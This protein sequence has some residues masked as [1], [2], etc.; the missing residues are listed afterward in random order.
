MGL[1][2]AA[3]D[4][5]STAGHFASVAREFGIPTLVN[6]GMATK[7]IASGQEVTVYA[8]AKVV[9][10]GEANHFIQKLEEMILGDYPIVDMVAVEGKLA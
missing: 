3:G 6:T 2:A 7:N 8:D 9:Y 4:V 1:Y 5:G 10:E